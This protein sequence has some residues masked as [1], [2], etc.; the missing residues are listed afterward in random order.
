MQALARPA[1]AS[2]MLLTGRR[3]PLY[4][5]GRQRPTRGV[6]NVGLEIWLMAKRCYYEI[7]G[8]ARGGERA[9][10]Q[11]GL[12][13]ARQG[14]PPRP[15]RRRQG[16]R[17]QVQGAERGL[18]GP[19]GPA[20][21]RRL[22]PVRPCRVR[23]R[24]GA[25][26]TASGPT[27]PPPCR[28]SS[29]TCSASSWAAGAAAQRSAAASAAPTCATTW[30]SRCRRRIAGKTAQIRVP[31]SVT[32][33]T[34]TGI[35]RQDRHPAD[36]PARPAAAPARCAPPRASSPSSA[37]AP[38]ARAAARSSTI[39]AAP[40]AARAA[41]CKE[42]TL[43][44]NI[45][46]G[47]EDGTKHPPRRRRRGRLARRAGRRPLHFPVDQAARVLPARRRRHLLP[48]ADLH[49]DGGARRPDRRADH[50]RRA[51]RA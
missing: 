41:S 28:T 51:R 1:E 2:N 20:E 45:P 7:L 19:E 50:R 30:R 39:P 24:T 22:R 35:G 37:P 5:R 43:S 17:A 4:V 31:T 25:A 33:T 13:P 3:G 6:T 8:L 32:C 47:V 14:L 26:A 48:R 16:R 40:A 29:T 21:A 49:D 12:P 38:P 18:R 42:R 11:V 36:A 15:Q 27:S 44:V 46:A 23:G 10:H 34:C 9:G